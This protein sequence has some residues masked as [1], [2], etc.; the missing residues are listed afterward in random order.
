MKKYNTN[1]LFMATPAQLQLICKIFKNIL[2]NKTESKYRNL[3]VNRISNKLNDSGMQWLYNAGFE[4]SNDNKRLLLKTQDINKLGDV[5]SCLMSVMP[6]VPNNCTSN[7]ANINRTTDNTIIPCQKNNDHPICVCNQKMTYTLYEGSANEPIPCD[8]C[9][10]KFFPKSEYFYLCTDDGYTICKECYSVSDAASAVTKMLQMGFDD[11][12]CLI[13]VLR[14]FKGNVDAALNYIETNPDYQDRIH[15]LRLLSTI[16]QKNNS[17]VDNYLNKKQEYMNILYFM[18]ELATAEDDIVHKADL[19]ENNCSSLSECEQLTNLRNLMRESHVTNDLLISESINLEEVLSNFLHLLKHHTNDEEFECISTSFGICDIEKCKMFKRNFRERNPNVDAVDIKNDERKIISQQILDKIHCFYCHC[20]DV[21]NK[22]NSSQKYKLSR[23][24]TQND[25]SSNLD[26]KIIFHDKLKIKHVRNII[27]NVSINK[28]G[29]KISRHNRFNMYQP[30]EPSNQQ[31]CYSFGCFGHVRYY[32]ITDEDEL[33]DPDTDPPLISEVYSSLKEELL[34]SKYININQFNNEYK[35]A[36]LLHNSTYNKQNVR[37][38]AEYILALMFYCNYD[39]LQYHFSR[40]FRRKY[41]DEPF[42]QV[43]ERHSHYYWFAKYL[44]K[45]VKECG[46]KIKSGNIKSFY[47]GVSEILMFAQTY[48]ISLQC[49]TSTS[50]SFEVAVNFTNQNKGMIVDFGVW[51]A[52]LTPAKYLCTPWLSDFGNESECLFLGDSWGGMKISNII[53]ASTGSSCDSVLRAL[54]IIESLCIHSNYMGQRMTH[55]DEQITADTLKYVQSLQLSENK[56]SDSSNNDQQAQYMLN[57]FFTKQ[58]WIEINFE[59]L[60]YVL[61]LGSESK[62][63]FKM[64]CYSQFEWIKLSF[65][66]LLFPNMEGITV[67]RIY[68]CTSVLECIGK[69]L[70]ANLSIKRILIIDQVTN[71]RS[72][73]LTA[74]DAVQKYAWFF[75]QKNWKMTCPRDGCLHLDKI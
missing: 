26:Q 46:T 48:G 12:F 40:T 60:M 19:N 68:L 65:L 16:Q 51:R 21:G 73:G 2:N 13:S 17:V 29:K 1:L 66:N 58:T 41:K 56:E 54:E 53:N 45:A 70:S 4:I 8:G 32:E 62:L 30:T 59:E 34:N 23:P 35:K 10:K 22:I 74:S 55:R 31:T 39:D 11:V 14:M 36:Q 71:Y 67:K 38:C 33:K 37:M 3:S 24:K 43:I 63:L 49:P 15:K 50:E 42:D 57:H 72:S 52:T 44:T 69:Q 5:Y 6:S 7:K 18:S 47:H 61:D 20:F 64:L 25:E 9:Y 27:D 75:K 28:N